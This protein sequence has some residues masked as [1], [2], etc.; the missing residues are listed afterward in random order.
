[1]LVGNVKE[2]LPAYDCHL[3]TNIFTELK[4]ILKSDLAMYPCSPWN[5]ESR[6][7]PANFPLLY[8]FSVQVGYVHFRSVPVK[9]ISFLAEVA[10]MVLLDI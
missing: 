3:S 6:G 8:I 10:V 2:S 1:M 9:N 4:T 5:I 7:I